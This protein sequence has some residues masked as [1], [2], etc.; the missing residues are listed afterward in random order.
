MSILHRFHLPE[1]KFRMPTLPERGSLHVE[2]PNVKGAILRFLKFIVSV[3]H[4]IWNN[5][6]LRLEVHGT[7]W[8]SVCGRGPCFYVHP[9]FRLGRTFVFRSMVLE[10]TDLLKLEL[11]ALGLIA[12]GIAPFFNLE[13]AFAFEDILIGVCLSL[14]FMLLA[15]FDKATTKMEIPLYVFV[16]AIV[17]YQLGNSVLI[18]DGTTRVLLDTH[19]IL[20]WEFLAPCVVTFLYL[21]GVEPIL[22]RIGR[23]KAP[24]SAARAMVPKY[25]QPRDDSDDEADI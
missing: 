9:A 13:T 25:E 17:V 7:V 15:A 10:L 23:V 21:L 24:E 16:T 1:V 22:R 8:G 14:G 12:F 3:L 18:R 20:G 2:F 11:A 4:W 5:W 19:S 6:P